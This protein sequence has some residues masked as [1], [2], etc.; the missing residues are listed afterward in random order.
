MEETC[1]SGFHTRLP[2]LYYE[3]IWNTAIFEGIDSRFVLSNGDQ[4]GL[5]YHGD[6]LNGWDIEVLQEAI[7]LCIGLSGRVEDCSP[8]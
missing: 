3:T 4:T 5:G 2:S 1:P 8:F 7:K 6:F